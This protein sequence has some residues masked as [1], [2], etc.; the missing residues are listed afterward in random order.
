MAS[1]NSWHLS[2]EPERIYLEPGNGAPDTG[3][4][5]CEDDVWDGD[6]DY[7]DDPPA[8]AYIRAD[9][10]PPLPDAEPVEGEVALDYLRLQTALREIKRE[11]DPDRM[12]STG[13]I[14]DEERIWY[15]ADEA[16]NRPGG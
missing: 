10:C 6:P 15:L 13:H 16:L 1:N 3:R 2:S 9:L 14:P 4:L 8:T 5:W 12:R 11:V 7:A